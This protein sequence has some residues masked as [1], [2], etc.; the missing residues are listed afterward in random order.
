MAPFEALYGRPCRSPSCWLETGERLV[1]GPD[2]VRDSIEKIDLIRLRMKEAQSRQKSYADNRRRKL[3][4]NVGDLVFLRVSPMKGVM[5]FSRS[6]KLAPR[7]IGPFPISERVGSVAYRVSLP[8]RFSS[9]HDVFHVSQLRRCLRDSE[10]IIEQDILDEVEISPNLTYEQQPIRIVATEIK[11][12]RNKDVPLVK[13]QW[14]ANPKD[15][16]WET[17]ESIERA[18]PELFSHTS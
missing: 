10:S 3:E 12:L 11:R 7:Y 18:H 17:R 1:L 4:F 16:S 13:I 6:G 2:L 5:R 15:C 9:I 14:S 8:D